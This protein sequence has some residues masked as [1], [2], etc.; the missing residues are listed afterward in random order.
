[1]PVPYGCDI[2]EPLK[3]GTMINGNRSSELLEL[4]N[5]TKV[6]RRYP[7]IRAVYVFGSTASGN[8]RPESD[9]DL[10]VIPANPSVREKRLDILADLAGHGY[11]DVDLVFID[12]D[13]LVLAYEAIR[14][15]RLIY[16]VEDFDRGTTY[17]IIVRKYL[18]F[19]PYL[20]IQR[21]A[22]KRRNIGAKS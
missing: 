10:A 19:E 13:D 21:G 6:F 2:V 1:M 3:E 8:T 20:R 16:A 15:N 7:G 14:Q 12:E 22:Y 9:L 11:C 5:L 18:D 17:S 4:A